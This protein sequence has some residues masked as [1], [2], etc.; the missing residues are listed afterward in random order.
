M[1]KEGRLPD[2]SKPF[3]MKGGKGAGRKRRPLHPKQS[4]DVSEKAN[5]S[6]TGKMSK[7]YQKKRKYGKGRLQRSNGV[8]EGEGRKQT[9][10][11]QRKAHPD[12]Q[13]TC[14]RGREKAGW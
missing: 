13:K 12:K 8:T 3:I 4:M 2:Q 11:I 14:G 7:K 5:K 9:Q 6:L 10:E 1:G